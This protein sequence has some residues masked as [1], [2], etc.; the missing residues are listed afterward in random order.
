M[1]PLQ[2]KNH[3]LR[4]KNQNKG[5]KLHPRYLK[6]LCFFDIILVDD[7]EVFLCKLDHTD[8]NC[9]V[10]P[11]DSLKATL[12]LLQRH[13]SVSHNITISRLKDKTAFQQNNVKVSLKSI[14]SHFK[15]YLC[16]YL[17]F[18]FTATKNAEFF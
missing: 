8:E 12:A 11:I 15:I 2:V 10:K 6:L 5:F 14:V 13:L 4:I 3:Y 9:Q 1:Q 7:K 18:A 16:F 17:F